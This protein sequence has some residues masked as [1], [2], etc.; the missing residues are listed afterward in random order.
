MVTEKEGDIRRG[1][2]DRYGNSWSVWKGCKR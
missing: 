2:W 1:G